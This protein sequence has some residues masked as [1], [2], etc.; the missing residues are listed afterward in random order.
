MTDRRRSRSRPMTPGIPKEQDLRRH[1]HEG[2]RKER[3]DLQGPEQNRA[4]DDRRYEA[5][6]RAATGQDEP[7]NRV[8]YTR[9]RPERRT[10]GRIEDGTPGVTRKT[11]IDSEQ[12]TKRRRP[13]STPPS[14]R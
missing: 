4:G 5:P 10:A 7:A 3:Q 11:V 13:R 14:R 9:A 8:R 12:A 6:A 2:G 1:R